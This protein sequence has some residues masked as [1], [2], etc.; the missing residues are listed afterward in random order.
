MSGLVVCIHVRC[1]C[2]GV[3]FGPAGVCRRPARIVPPYVLED[4]KAGCVIAAIRKGTLVLLEKIV[5]ILPYIHY[6]LL[7]LMM[8]SASSNYRGSRILLM[9][10]AKR[11]MGSKHTF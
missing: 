4:E 9:L 10:I 6:L 8:D 1:F 3:F 5:P 11:P 2:G 7:N